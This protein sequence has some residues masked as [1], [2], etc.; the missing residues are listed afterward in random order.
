MNDLHRY[1]ALESWLFD[2]QERRLPRMARGVSVASKALYERM[3][4]FGVARDRILYLPNCASAPLP[5]DGTRIRERFGIDASCPVVLLYTRFFE[6]SQERLAWLCAEIAARVPAVRLLVVGKGQRG[7][8]EMLRN[9]SNV[10]GF[11]PNLVLAGWMD[12]AEIPDYLDAGDV[13]VYPFADTAVNRSKCP[14][15]LTELMRAGRAVVAHRIGMIAEYIREGDSGILCDPDDWRS[16]AEH[17]VS[18]LGDAERRR[19][20]GRAAQERIL[21]DFSWQAYGERLALFYRRLAGN[22]STGKEAA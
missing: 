10:N 1:S 18:L 21:G 9:A 14:A 12:A 19:S 17:V 15:K 8:E 7:E 3:A 13:A 6:F 11:T 5:G 22:P 16:M 2:F 20:L 4:G